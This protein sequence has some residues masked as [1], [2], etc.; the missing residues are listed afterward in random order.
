[1]ATESGLQLPVWMED[2]FKCHACSTV[3]AETPVYRCFAPQN[4]L[5]C[6]KCIKLNAYY[7]RPLC[8]VCTKRT[9]CKSDT[10]AEQILNQLPKTKCMYEAC[11]FQKADVETVIAHELSC[12]HRLV[13]CYTCYKCAPMSALKSHILETHDASEEFSLTFGKPKSLYCPVQ[14]STGTIFTDVFQIEENEKTFTFFSHIAVEYGRYIFWMTQTDA[15][16]VFRYKVSAYALIDDDG[17]DKRGS[18]LA[19]FSGSC[20]SHDTPPSAMKKSLF[21]L[22][23][24]VDIIEDSLNSEDRYELV[25]TISKP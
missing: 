2:F 10:L 12:A 5:I 6:Q 7:S 15:D 17:D 9:C 25:F 1:M 11:Q 8:P 14:S 19:E 23:I 21:C 4:H 24:P 20:T 18:N 16:Q 22:T 3:T 13:L